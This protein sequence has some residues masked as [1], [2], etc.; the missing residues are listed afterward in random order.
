MG[1]ETATLPFI[2]G[3]RSLF[4]YPKFKKAFLNQNI[5]WI[6]ILYNYLFMTI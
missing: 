3:I 6:V 1:N 4:V 2:G 5:L